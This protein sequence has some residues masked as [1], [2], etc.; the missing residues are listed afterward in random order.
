MGDGKCILK[1]VQN[2]ID[3]EGIG[4]LLSK[5]T[6]GMARKLGRDEGEAAQVK[7]LEMPMHEDLLAAGNRS[8]NLK[9]A[10]SNLCGVTRDHDQLPEICLEPLSEGTTDGVQ[11]DMGAMLKGYYQYH[12]WDWES[13]K[14]TKD[15]LIELGLGQVA[16]KL[17]S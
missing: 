1:L 6:L 3:Q 13:G 5:G 9:R 2:I 16:D 15:K 12:G 10:I 7:G 17:Y 14:P 4:S 8:I 11:P